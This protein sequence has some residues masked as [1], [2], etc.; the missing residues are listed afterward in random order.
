M[1]TLSEINKK[2]ESW[3]YQIA[4]NSIT[5]YYRSRKEPLELNDFPV[6]DEYPEDKC[7]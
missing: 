7:T 2:L 6:V 5:D 4:R 3:V 1:L